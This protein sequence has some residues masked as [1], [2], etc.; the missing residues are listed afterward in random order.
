MNNDTIKLFFSQSHSLQI[1]DPFYSQWR[2]KSKA[3]WEQ[4]QHNLKSDIP[5]WMSENLY[6]VIQR[7]L[8]K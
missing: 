2:A 4:Y 5:S 3:L 7:E 6:K 1:E 8:K